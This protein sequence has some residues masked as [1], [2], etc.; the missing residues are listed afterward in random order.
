MYQTDYGLGSFTIVCGCCGWDKDR[1]S[2]SSAIAEHYVKTELKKSIKAKASGAVKWTLNAR[3]I[4]LATSMGS[5]SFAT[6][7]NHVIAAGE[8]TPRREYDCK[9]TGSVELALSSHK[10]KRPGRAVSI[11]ERENSRSTDGMETDGPKS[12]PERGKRECTSMTIPN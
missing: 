7:P 1:R 9:S 2:F 12:P 8:L 3:C 11:C 10:S 6:V 5:T 4:F